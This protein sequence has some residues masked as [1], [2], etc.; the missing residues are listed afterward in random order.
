MSLL[1]RFYELLSDEGLGEATRRGLEYGLR[2]LYLRVSRNPQRMYVDSISAIADQNGINICRNEQIRQQ[3]D[4]AAT[5][6][7]IATESP[8]V[9]KDQDWLDPSFDF[10]AEFSFG[11]FYDLDRFHSLRRMHSVVDYWVELELSNPYGEKP[12][13]VSTVLSE[14]NQLPGHQMRHDVADSYRK[15]IDCYGAGANRYIEEKVAS[16]G[17]YM[18]QVVIENGQYPEYVSEKFYDCIKT[19]TVP[20]YWG[21]EQA[22]IE[23]G[24]D[25]EGILFFDDPSELN[26][27]LEII[28]PELYRQFRPHVEANR[29]R[30]V[31]IR[32]ELR[33]EFYFDMVRLGSLRAKDSAPSKTGK[34]NLMME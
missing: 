27:L 34:Y 24:F 7:L 31:E 29:R 15:L 10:H 13:L 1:R 25:T 23:M 12:R 17:P 33:Q 19:N 32:N 11:D 16:L 28:S 26:D 3:Y 4:P 6:V 21:G 14:K 20:I 9:V 2:D 18:F 8:A 5:N 30:L 22:V